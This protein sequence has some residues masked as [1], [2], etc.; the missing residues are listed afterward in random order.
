MGENDSKR[1]TKENIRVLTMGGLLAS[2]RAAL[3]GGG[4]E[5]SEEVSTGSRY[6]SGERGDIHTKVR[7]RT[8][9]QRE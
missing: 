3:L 6:D 2:A 8:F 1:V 4:G 5:R 7:A 9:R